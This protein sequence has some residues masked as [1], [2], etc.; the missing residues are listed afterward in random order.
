[1]DAVHDGERRPCAFGRARP[2]ERRRRR[3]R[4][5]V[6][7][8]RSLPGETARLGPGGG[9][10]GVERRRRPCDHPVAGRSEDGAEPIGG[11]DMAVPADMHHADR[12][13]E[14]GR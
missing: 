5:G 4:L 1:V 2:L 12:R 13:H 10:L 6:V 14:A 8:R 9:D 11:A 7:F 3:R